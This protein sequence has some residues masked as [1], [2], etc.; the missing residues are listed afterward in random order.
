MSPIQQMF[1]GTLS[2]GGGGPLLLESSDSSRYGDTTTVQNTWWGNQSYDSSV[3]TNIGQ[4]SY[5]GFYA[6]TVGAACNLTA[7]LKGAAGWSNSRGRSITSTF[8]LSVNDRIVFFAG[9]PTLKALTDQQMGGGG[10]ASCL[11]KYSTSL[12]GDAN[13]ENGFVPLIIAAGGSAAGN[14]P[15]TKDAGRYRTIEAVALNITTNNTHSNLVTWRKAAGNSG[16]VSSPGNQ[17]DFDGGWGRG[18]THTGGAGWK[19]PAVNYNNGQICSGKN[20]SGGN[21]GTEVG[22]A[23]G[24]VGM[25]RQ[26]SQNGADGGFGGGGADSTSNY[27]APGGGGY[28]G[29]F[30][31][32]GGSH[33][34][35]YYYTY[36]GDVNGG[37]AFDDRGG[38]LS[39]VHSSGS[40]TTDNGYNGSTSS[41]NEQNNAN[42]IKGSVELVFS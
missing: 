27:Y 21:A 14:N 6:F 25:A 31:N 42:Q 3:I 20:S 12:S 16:S 13:Y 22:I 30:E 39:F 29:G 36:G 34:D 8:S 37:N 32:S 23:Y 10:G 18:G 19:Y 2:G 40:N 9:K 7:T 38:P 4:Q 17:S 5:Q 11:M 15:S 33:S 24:A 35:S 41:W 1:L 26:S 28:F